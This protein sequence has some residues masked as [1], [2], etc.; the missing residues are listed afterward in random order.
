MAGAQ[1][2]V[3]KK[4]NLFSV[5]VLGD[6]GSGTFAGAIAGADAVNAAASAR[7]KIVN[8]SLGGNRC[9]AMND[10][11]NA[12]TDTLYVVAS[13]NSNLDACTVSPASAENAFTVNAIHQQTNFGK[14]V[15]VKASFSNYGPC[16]KIFAPGNGVL[17][18]WSSS[19]TATL[20]ISGTSMAAPHVAGVAALLV[21][22]SAS[23]TMTQVKDALINL[24]TADIITGV[25]T[26]SPNLLVY[27][28][29]A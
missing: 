13:G 27:N 11:I 16:T 22:E 5:K 14:L 23:L 26:G 19:D 29:A 4:A 6:N 24:A 15:D 25:G 12:A 2:G 20:S 8:M 17:A 7:T 18:A 10:I 3:A 1:Y 9:T 21:G 28:D